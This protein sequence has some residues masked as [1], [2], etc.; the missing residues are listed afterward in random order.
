MNI[1]QVNKFLT[2]MNESWGNYNTKIAKWTSRIFKQFAKSV[3]ETYP[4]LQDYSDRIAISKLLLVSSRQKRQKKYCVFMVPADFI[5]GKPSIFFTFFPDEKKTTFSGGTSFKTEENKLPND[6]IVIHIPMFKNSNELS[7]KISQEFFW[8]ELNDTLNHELTHYLHEKDMNLEQYQKGTNTETLLQW[9]KYHLQEVEMR[10]TIQG[11]MAHFKKGTSL[12][13]Y[14]NDR[15]KYIFKK[16]ST[17]FKPTLV[18]LYLASFVSYIHNNKTMF[19]RY[20][21][22]LVNDK[23]VQKYVVDETTLSK[24][25]DAMNYCEKSIEELRKAAVVEVKGVKYTVIGTNGIPEIRELEV[26]FYAKEAKSAFKKFDADSLKEEM[27]KFKSY[28]KERMRRTI[29]LC[30]KQM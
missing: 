12:L 24:F 2:S 23:Q 14:L 16:N 5:E 26:Q 7:N 9:V 6:R 4:A 21:K 22:N 18:K 11:W 25:M 15:A 1:F 3:K 30:L 20:W 27:D 19:N 17:K 13:D 29:E 28:W 8:T 10:A